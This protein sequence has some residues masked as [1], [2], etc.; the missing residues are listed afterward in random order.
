MRPILARRRSSEASRSGHIGDA[1]EKH[2]AFL[3]CFPFIMLLKNPEESFVR[4]K[5][6]IWTETL[7][8]DPK[9]YL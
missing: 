7:S 5:E 4:R 2:I 9:P 3:V 6:K 1:L 8:D